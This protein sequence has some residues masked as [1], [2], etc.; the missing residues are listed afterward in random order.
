ML[1][2]EG[3]VVGVEG[4]RAVS[5]DRAGHT[6]QRDWEVPTELA[7]ILE[8]GRDVGPVPRSPR[9]VAA[10]DSLG[11]L[12]DQLAVVAAGDV[13]RPLIV[14][15]LSSLCS[16]PHES[17]PRSK[18]GIVGCLTRP[19]DCVA[20]DVGSAHRQ[21]PHRPRCCRWASSSAAAYVL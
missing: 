20:Q 10:R 16:R 11:S 8:D 3:Q 1:A 17:P 15:A 7:Q 14:R 21:V 19:G 2:H 12:E 5:V 18:G 4:E 6:L 13:S 9:L